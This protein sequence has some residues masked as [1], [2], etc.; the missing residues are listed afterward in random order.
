MVK[1]CPK[2]ASPFTS[3]NHQQKLITWARASHHLHANKNQVAVSVCHHPNYIGCLGIKH[4]YLH[5]RSQNEWHITSQ[6]GILVLSITH[7]HKRKWNITTWWTVIHYKSTLP[8]VLQGLGPFPVQQLLHLCFCSWTSSSGHKEMRSCLSHVPGCCHKTP[9]APGWH[10]L[11]CTPSMRLGPVHPGQNGTIC[12]RKNKTQ[13]DFD[14]FKCKALCWLATT[15]S[16]QK[17]KICYT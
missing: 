17:L 14:Y 16:I 15:G 8:A 13:S 5:E 2:T 12:L 9:S 11:G 4:T 7:L 10:H 3:R 1:E 6:Y